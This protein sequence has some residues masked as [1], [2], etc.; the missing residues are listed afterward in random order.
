MERISKTKH[1][2]GGKDYAPGEPVDVHPTNIRILGA[3]GRI[4]LAP[5]DYGYQAAPSVPVAGQTAEKLADSTENPSEIASESE[6]A[7][8]AG[9]PAEPAAVASEV[10]PPAVAPAPAAKP[11]KAP[12][13]AVA[14]K[15][16][17]AK[18]SAKKAG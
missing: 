4:E 13:K 8:D 7:V 17:A 14:K 3:L 18:K 10:S 2:Y 16:V 6:I 11:A 12:A 15:P 1:R 9:A 5:S